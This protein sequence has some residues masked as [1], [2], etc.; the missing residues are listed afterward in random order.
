MNDEI[1]ADNLFR[2]YQN[3]GL[4]LNLQTMAAS[5]YAGFEMS[6]LCVFNGKIVGINQVGIYEHDGDLDAGRP[7]N[8]LFRPVSVDLGSDADKEVRVLN[9]SGAMEGNLLITP[10]TDNEE[11]HG[12]SFKSFTWDQTSITVGISGDNR[13][14]FWSFEI[15]NINGSDF[16]ID[17]LYPLFAVLV[18]T[19][20]TAKGIIGILKQDAPGSDLVGTGA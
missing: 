8:A 16:S 6:S 3:L 15:S 17:A 1:V 14:R 9:I 20:K 13:G 5:Q 4:A 12:T 11:G 7:I 2:E 19:H 10:Y 18:N